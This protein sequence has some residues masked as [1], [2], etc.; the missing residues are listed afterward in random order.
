MSAD[1]L[2]LRCRCGAL[3]GTL[4]SARATMH[5]ICYCRDCRAYLH[6]LG[7]ADASDARGGMAFVA[8]VAPDVTLDDQQHRLACVSLSPRGTLRWYAGCCA[9][10][11][12]NTARDWRLPYVGLVHTCVDRAALDAAFRAPPLDVNTASAHVPVPPSRLRVAV[13]LAGFAPRLLA[14][15]VGGAYRRTPFFRAPDGRP[16]AAPRVITRDERERAYAAA[17][18]PGRG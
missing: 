1:A 10:P 4:R 8:A 15:R 5:G 3:R 17:A 14:A 11:I 16:C 6:H 9:T 13:A 2:A 7:R 18:A 12:A